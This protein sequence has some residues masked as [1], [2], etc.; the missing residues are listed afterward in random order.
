MTDMFARGI[1]HELNSGKYSQ[2]PSTWGLAA[3]D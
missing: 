3:I 1:E 2:P